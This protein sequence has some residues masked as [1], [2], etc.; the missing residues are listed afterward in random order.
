MRGVVAGTRED[1]TG[2][3]GGDGG[4]EIVRIF[5]SGAELS[6]QLRHPMDLM[7]EGIEYAPIRGV[8]WI[9]KEMGA[10]KWVTEELKARL[11]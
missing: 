3:G 9:K 11:R 2:Y 4:Q 10:G 6:L 5:E 1:S 8:W 7:P